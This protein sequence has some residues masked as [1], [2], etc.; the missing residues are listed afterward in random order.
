MTEDS[1]ITVPID[2]TWKLL[3]DRAHF[4]SRNEWVEVRVRTDPR[5]GDDYI[6]LL[7]GVK[8]QNPH[9]HL[10]IN[11]DLK[12]RFAEP[13]GR[14]NSIQREVVD[15]QLGKV[16]DTMVMLK[17]TKGPYKFA[18]RIYADEPTRTVKLA[19]EESGILP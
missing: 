10:G 14:L 19:I 3:V 17:E 8:G 11:R 18:L 12:L 1:I 13:R 2:S 7:I 9:I 15:S 6:D 4:D 16:D 5:R